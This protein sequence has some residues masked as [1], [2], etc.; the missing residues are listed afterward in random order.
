LGFSVVGILVV[1]R[2]HFKLFSA[3]QLNLHWVLRLR[4]C[5]SF[6]F[7]RPLYVNISAAGLPI[8]QL[9]CC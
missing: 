4:L 2:T 5:C 9:F 1:L 8:N 7:I 3:L 6:L